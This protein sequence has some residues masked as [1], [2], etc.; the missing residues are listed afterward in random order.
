[1]FTPGEWPGSP[2]ALEALPIAVTVELLKCALM[3]IGADEI[4]PKEYGM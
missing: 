3:N 4:F 1:V 2:L